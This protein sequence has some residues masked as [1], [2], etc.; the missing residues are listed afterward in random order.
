MNF[1]IVRYLIGWMLGI[2][3]IF[4]L[5]PAL[6][7]VIYGEAELPAYLTAAAISLAGAALLC[8]RKPKNTRFYAREGY[9]TVALC[10]LVLAV[11]GAL[12]FVLSREIPFFIDALFETV[13]GFT[14]TGATILGDVEALSHA[15]ML[16]RCLTHWVGG[17]VLCRRITAVDHKS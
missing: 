16:W 4:L 15:S 9:V 12:P 7:A 14:T 6:T 17:M 10:W 8:H 5:L 3:S 13:S 11:I 1:A 2:E